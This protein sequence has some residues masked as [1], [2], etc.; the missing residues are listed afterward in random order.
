MKP[1]LRSLMLEFQPGA[2]AYLSEIRALSTDKDGNDVFVGL[3]A[4]ESAWYATYL[5]ESFRGTA[6]RSDGP[7]GRYLALQDKHEEAR[8]AV[9]ADEVLVHDQ[10]LAQARKPTKPG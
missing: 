1:Y 10:A 7:Q 2:R 3:T 6:D 8:Q 4:E 9:I 5:E